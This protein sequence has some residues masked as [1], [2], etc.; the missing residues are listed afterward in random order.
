[1]F[2]N[3]SVA[4]MALA[5]PVASIQAPAPQPVVLVTKMDMPQFLPVDVYEEERVQSNEEKSVVLF[6]HLKNE[7]E[8]S[9]TAMSD[10]LGVKRRTLYNW[11]KEPLKSRQYGAQIESRLVALSNLKDEME[12]EHRSALRKIA[13]SPIYGDKEFGQMILDGASDVVLID[14]YDQLF[15][16]FE[17]YRKLNNSKNSMT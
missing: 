17:S 5:A 15:S 3:I 12:P 9:H 10:W 6:H 11:L 8:L 7:F 2:E 13:F 4:V 14:F 1:M 16:Q